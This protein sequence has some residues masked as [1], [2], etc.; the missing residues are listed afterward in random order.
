L[1][2]RLTRLT[3]NGGTAMYDAVADAAPLAQ[4]GRHRKKALLIISDGND[5]NSQTTVAEVKSLIRET[6]VMVYAIGIDGASTSTTWG[7]GG[8]R[9][10]PRQPPTT[11]P[12]PFPFPGGRRTPPPTQPQPRS[13]RG[14]DERVNAAA[15]RAITDDSGGRTEIVRSARD[16]DPATTNIA[17]ELSKQYSLGYPASGT[18]DGRWHAIVVE[19]RGERYRVRARRGYVANP[20]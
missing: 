15:L 5:T 14:I 4:T 11:F 16:L 6:E 1:Q 19:V 13:S 7:G 20:E 8:T 9:L 3:P 2:S 17:D 10:P 12:F 18:R